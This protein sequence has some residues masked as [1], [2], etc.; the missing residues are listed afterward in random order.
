MTTGKRLETYNVFHI[1]T[2]FI[3]NIFCRRILKFP[4]TCVQ[5]F[6]YSGRFSQVLT[7]IPRVGP[8]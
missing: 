5:I 7:K 6:R 8:C 3:R 4:Q 1:F 2:T